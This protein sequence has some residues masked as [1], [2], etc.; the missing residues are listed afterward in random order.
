MEG[1]REWDREREGDRC[2]LLSLDRN[3][4]QFKSMQRIETN[5]MRRAK[6]EKKIRAA[7]MV[8]QF[9]LVSVS[10]PFCLVHRLMKELIKPGMGKTEKWRKWGDTTMERQ[11][12]WAWA[13]VY[14]FEGTSKRPWSERRAKIIKNRRAEPEENS[15]ANTAL[16]RFIEHYI[17]IQLC[18]MVFGEWRIPSQIAMNDADADHRSTTTLPNA[19]S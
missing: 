8:Q 10:L 16:K 1:P 5:E 19:G 11:K 6:K 7:K 4:A 14:T 15:R 3:C 2:Q 13:I 18:K 17:S 9:L 12:S